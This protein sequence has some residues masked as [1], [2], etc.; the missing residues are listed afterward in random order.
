MKNPLSG[1]G[2]SL[3]GGLSALWDAII[4]PVTILTM[5]LIAFG[6]A[7][8]FG[9]DYTTLAWPAM[10]LWGALLGWIPGKR[11]GLWLINVATGFF[12]LSA[13]ESG[14]GGIIAI[15]CGVAGMFIMDAWEDITAPPPPKPQPQSP[16]AKK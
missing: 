6:C 3:K 12:V 13:L 15:F 10:C 1:V 5:A 9:G 4:K 14:S 16:P 8:L 7:K 11:F 2:S